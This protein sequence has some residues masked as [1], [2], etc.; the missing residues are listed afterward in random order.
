MTCHERILPA[1]VVLAFLEACSG[2]SGQTDAGNPDSGSSASA[3]SGSGTSGTGGS[4]TSSS[5]TTSSGTSG[6]CAT[7]QQPTGSVSATVTG[8]ESASF[9]LNCVNGGDGSD[10]QLVNG[11]SYFQLVDGGVESST[12]TLTFFYG[13]S[14][15]QPGPGT[16]FDLSQHSCLQIS[17]TLLV[18][19]ATAQFGNVILSPPYASGTFAL[20]A[21]STAS[22]GTVAGT[23]S[24]AVLPETDQGSGQMS[25]SGSYSAINP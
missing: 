15:C 25:L 24:N 22:G 13:T 3:T 8:T 7:G 2:G 19:G 9:I 14:E 10:G 16:S 11:V 5:G 4:G 21:W 18:A 6:F 17:G 12:V 23:F 1:M 20:T